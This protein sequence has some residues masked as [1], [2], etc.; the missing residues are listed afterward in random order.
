MKTPVWKI[1][2]APDSEFVKKFSEQLNNLPLPIATILI[3]RGID[4]FEK[5]K[6]YFRPNLS[7]LYDPFLMKD[8]K[9]AVD[10]LVEAIKNNEKILIYG[11]Y[12]V[13][14]TTAVTLVYDFLKRYYANLEFYI[15]DRY[16]EGYG[17]SYRG[18]DYAH[19]NDFSLI[20][21]LDCGI[22]A[23]EKV[24]YAMDKG[25]DIIICDHH[26]PGEHLPP[27]YAILNPK[28]K[29]CGYPFKELTGCGVGY[30]FM[31]AFAQRNHIHTGELNEYIDLLAVSI[32]A[33]IVPIED[34]NR[35]L[36]YFGLKK[37]N[38]NPLPGIKAI[39]N[40]AGFN[41]NE[42]TVSDIVFVIAPRINAAGRIKDA[43]NAVN[44]LLAKNPDQ[45]DLHASIINE[46]NINRREFDETATKE[47]IAILESNDAYK[48]KKTT[49]VFK[50]DWHK[51]V[52]GI[53][54]S[55]LIEYYY[56]PTVVL[57]A[58]DDNLISGSARSVPGFDLYNAIAQCGDLLEQ[59]GGHKYAAGLT[60]KQENLDKFIEKFEWIVSQTIR[61]EHMTPYLEIDT[62]ISLDDI[63][64]KFLRILKQMAPF[65][66]GNMRPVFLARN[67]RAGKYVS[68]V[69]Q[70][71]LKFNIPKNKDNQTQSIPAIAFGFGEYYRP[72]SEGSTFDAVFT[73]EENHFNGRTTY[74]MKIKDLRIHS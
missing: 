72:I 64:G 20:I 36:T 16:L 17:L 39:L 3:Q 73:L 49:V 27:A 8:M 46:L 53:V 42:V 31:Q 37:I 26:Q 57:T 7:N 19:E 43:R 24:L 48:S 66:P 33:D 21:T 14:G 50:Q 9:R 13:D 61:E 4:T 44:T 56:R 30:K 28:Q 63:T 70:N 65:G 71:H 6:R 45:A 58:S 15:P 5:A 55:R 1:S 60:L 69:G 23:V 25:I 59:F 54:A 35:I 51:G 41:R 11:D 52:V 67:L 12:D 68:I 29:D 10:R 62:E 34:E 47:A 32:A 40:V 38:E 18:I 22:K 2:P 74:Q